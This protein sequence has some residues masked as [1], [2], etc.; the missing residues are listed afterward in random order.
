MIQAFKK[1]KSFGVEY[2]NN[3]DIRIIAFVKE[4]DSPKQIIEK[5]VMITLSSK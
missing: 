2:P 1:I 5:T 4:K 3:V